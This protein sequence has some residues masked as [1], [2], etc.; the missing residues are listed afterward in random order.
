MCFKGL[1]LR[2]RMRKDV[3]KVARLTEI[4]RK[5]SV[6]SRSTSGRPRCNR[7]NE[8]EF[9]MEISTRTWMT[10]EIKCRWIVK[11]RHSYEIC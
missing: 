3:F 6:G 9:L 8:I 4:V 7:S 1:C 10:W 5:A 11:E 2:K